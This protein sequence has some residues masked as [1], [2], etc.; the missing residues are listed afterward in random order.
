MDDFKIFDVGLLDS[1][2]ESGGGISPKKL[3]FAVNSRE[4]LVNKSGFVHKQHENLSK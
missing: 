2:T 1:Q 4:F 3:Q